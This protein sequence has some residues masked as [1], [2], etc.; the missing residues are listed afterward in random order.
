MLTLY[1]SSFQFL[2]FY[3]EKER[4]C[5]KIRRDGAVLH[6]LH[7]AALSFLWEGLL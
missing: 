6:F 4:R 1:R 3:Q 7:L 5:L 2:V